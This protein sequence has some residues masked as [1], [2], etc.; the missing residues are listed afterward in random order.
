MPSMRKSF[1][2]YAPR[3]VQKR[4]IAL[5][6]LAP[7]L[8]KHESLAEQFGES[9]ASLARQIYLRGLKGFEKAK[10]TQSAA[11]SNTHE[12]MNRP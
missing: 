11:A 5:R 6:L 9:S 7:E 8:A 10:S 4:A 2:S 12:G 1:G 3:G